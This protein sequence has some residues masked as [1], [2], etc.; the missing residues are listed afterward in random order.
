MFVDLLKLVREVE[1]GKRWNI[2]VC[3]TP[4]EFYK[5]VVE[6]AAP[7]CLA[8]FRDEDT[9]LASL[10]AVRQGRPAAF[11]LG[12][13]NPATLHHHEPDYTT[14]HGVVGRPQL[15]SAALEVLMFRGA[16]QDAAMRLEWLKT[17]FGLQLGLPKAPTDLL[18]LME[19]L[20]DPSASVGAIAAALE[21]DV[22]IAA[23]TL[24]L[25][26]S[27]Y[28]NLPRRVDN[29]HQAVS[30]LGLESVKSLAVASKCFSAASEK[31]SAQVNA[32]ID[33]VRKQGT[34]VSQLL[35]R[36][37]GGH[38][39]GAAVTAAVLVDIGQVVMLQQFGTDY[40]RLQKQAKADDAPLH[41]R[42]HDAFGFSHAE[43]GGALLAHWGLPSTLVDPVTLSHTAFPHPAHGITATSVLYV[44]SAATDL[45]AATTAN[46]G[47]FETALPQRW[48]ELTGFAGDLSIPRWLALAHEIQM[49]WLAA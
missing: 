8:A 33:N 47:S 32:C 4:E 7:I 10:S 14:L 27:A 25:A 31:P 21:K 44:A 9:N 37:M 41:L 23:Q 40:V 20:E 39:D 26:N 48:A 3:E 19:I 17:N 42:E 28:F 1:R 6:T 24:R 16:E 34:A 12:L 13:V 46:D 49:H 43:A 18:Q 2:T 30:L 29:L 45:A 36:M 5:T 35:R 38:I 11:R 15:R 22:F